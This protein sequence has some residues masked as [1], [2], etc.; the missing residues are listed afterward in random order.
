MSCVLCVF[1]ALFQPRLL[2]SSGYHATN[3]WTEILST[4]PPRLIP[5][6]YPTVLQSKN[7]PQI[8]NHRQL[9][10]IYTATMLY[11]STPLLVFVK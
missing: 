2:V 10:R 1:I 6:Y 9:N 7:Q 8:R 3:Q 5:S 11:T 4:P